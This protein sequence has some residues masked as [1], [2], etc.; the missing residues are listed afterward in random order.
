MLVKFH[1]H[2]KGQGR[3]PIDYLLGKDRDREDAKVL[4]GDPDMQERIIDSVPYVQK[5]TSG[6][7]SFEEA[8]IPEEQKQA[9]MDS[10]EKTLLPGLDQDQYSILWVEHTDKDRLELN[11]VTAEIELLS[12]KRLQSYYA[13]VDQKR[14]NAWK[15]I[16]NNLCDFTDP[17]D[18]TK[19]RVTSDLKKKA[20]KTAKQVHQD[21]TEYITARIADGEVENRGDV[22]QAIEEY[23]LNITRETPKTISIDN[24]N[25]GNKIRLKGAIYEQ[26]FRVSEESAEAQGERLSAHRANRQQRL[27]EDKQLYS[28]LFRGKSEENRAKHKRPPEKFAPISLETINADFDKRQRRINLTSDSARLLLESDPEEIRV[29]ATELHDTTRGRRNNENSVLQEGG[30]GSSMHG[31]LQRAKVPKRQSR[32]SLRTNKTIKALNKLIKSHREVIRGYY[33][34]VSSSIDAIK[35]RF[36]S[37]TEAN[38]RATKR[39]TARHLSLARRQ[40]QQRHAHA[41]RASRIRNANLPKQSMQ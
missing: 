14:V 19:K 40:Q 41:Q 30:S 28:K 2:G 21:I 29:S 24:P 35:D 36:R 22:I 9:L 4:R 37:T 15:D 27:K 6:V 16:V 7:L 20:S 39:L 11:F 12:G 32:D 10:F 8:N 17:N 31:G 23:G 33:R 38:R 25:G 18:P 13:P 3:G 5:Y 26:D 1:S 34:S